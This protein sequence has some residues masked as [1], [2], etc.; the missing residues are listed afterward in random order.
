M[1]SLDTFHISLEFTIQRCLPTFL[2]HLNLTPTM[3]DATARRRKALRDFY[4]IQQQNAK[5]DEK[6]ENP[7]P[8]ASEEPPSPSL[9]PDDG[10]EDYVK[11]LVMKSDIKA[12]LKTENNLLAEIKGLDS[13]QKALIYNNYD[14]LITTSN[15]LDKQMNSAQDLTMFSEVSRKLTK[16]SELMKTIPELPA[17]SASASSDSL[18]INREFQWLKNVEFEIEYSAT[19]DNISKARKL[20]ND[21][22]TLIDTWQPKLQS[23]TLS[24]IRE[25]CHKLILEYKLNDKE[26]N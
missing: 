18:F 20:A 22:I 4:Q 16:V 6:S 14:K 24:D 3:S 25:S 23:K 1:P 10:M 2:L 17:K 19:H 15:M 8:S 5:Q 26:S 13:E 12:L 7:Q 11:N 21:A 9:I